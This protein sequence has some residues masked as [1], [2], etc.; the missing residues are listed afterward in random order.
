MKCDRSVKI[1]FL[2]ADPSDA[3]RLRLGQESRDIGER[4]QLGKEGDK[5]QLEQR[6]SV[7]VG[8]ITQSIFDL[9]PEIIHFSGHGTEKGELWFE[10]ELG[11][12]QPVEADALAAM[13]ELFAT[14]VN[15]VVLNACYSEIQAQ[16][17][18]EHI[19]FVIGMNDEIGDEAAINFA[20]GFYKALAANRS[21]EDAYKFGCVEI[22]LQGIPEHHKPVIHVKKKI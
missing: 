15:C 17:I 7:R 19:P 12:I 13:F 18:A 2:A 8:D 22:R 9:E 10:N 14:Q 4:L 11:K 3:A 5:Y 16:A 21:I 1:L 20:V 6:Y